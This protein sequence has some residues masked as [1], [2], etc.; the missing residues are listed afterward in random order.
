MLAGENHL[1]PWKQRVKDAD[2]W[3]IIDRLYMYI[4]VATMEYTAQGTV[5]FK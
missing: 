4:N 1:L 5:V 3:S 2:A